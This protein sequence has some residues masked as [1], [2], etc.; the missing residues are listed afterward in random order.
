VAQKTS[1]GKLEIFVKYTS[2]LELEKC[3]AVQ[4]KVTFDQ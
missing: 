3:P 2:L 4:Y 1:L